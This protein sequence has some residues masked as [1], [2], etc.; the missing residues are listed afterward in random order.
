MVSSAIPFTGQKWKVYMGSEGC[1]PLNT[2]KTVSITGV[3]LT[4]ADGANYSVNPTA[5]ALADITA[6]NNNPAITTTRPAPRSR[7]TLC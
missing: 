5:S 7:R 6:A 3:A 4:G 1:V 2:Q